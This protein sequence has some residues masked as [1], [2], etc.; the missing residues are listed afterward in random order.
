MTDERLTDQLAERGLG[1]R[2]APGR[3]LTSGRSWI[4]RS[5]FRPFVDVRDALRVLE[6]VTNDYSLVATPGGAFTV[7]VRLRGR[8]GRA[9]GEPKA[10]AI[11]LAIAQAMALDVAPRAGAASPPGVRSNRARDGNR[12]Q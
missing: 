10:R 6:A 8:V 12:G 7:E 2:L 3:F 1:W 4:P 9:V 11:S 5:R